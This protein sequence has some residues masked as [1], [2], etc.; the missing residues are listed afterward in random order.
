MVSS[1]LPTAM[2]RAGGVIWRLQTAHLNLEKSGLDL[3]GYL[4]PRASAGAALAYYS[5]F[6]LGPP[7]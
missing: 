7:D 1:L 2:S 5:V 3:T 4:P 6:S